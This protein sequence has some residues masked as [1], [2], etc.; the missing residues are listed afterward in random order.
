MSEEFKDFDAAEYIDDLEDIEY[1]L[2]NAV[3]TADLAYIKDSLNDVARS[4]GMMEIT[5]MT[6]L[7]GEQLLA[8]LSSQEFESMESVIALMKLMG[9]RLASN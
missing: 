6:G 2:E 7:T 8:A 9:L 5:N 3:E 1:F 4:K